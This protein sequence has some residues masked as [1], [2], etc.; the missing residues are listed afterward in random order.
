MLD[1]NPHRKNAGA[2]GISS[3]K[4]LVSW[5]L[6]RVAVILV[7]ASRTALGQL[8]PPP[9]PAPPGHEPPPDLR[10]LKAGFR[11]NLLA[12]AI[13]EMKAHREELLALEKKLALAQDFASAV[14]VRDERVRTEKQILTLEQEAAILVSRPAVGNAAKLVARIELK[15]SEA[16]LSDVQLDAKDGALTDWGQPNAGAT[17]QLSGLAPGGYEVLLRC[18]GPAGDVVVKEGFY[19]LTKTCKATNDKSVEQSLGTLRLRVGASSLTLGRA[20]SEKGTGWR[21][22]SVVLV[23]STI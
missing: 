17:W 2:L 9:A 14:R 13:P 10:G 12:A 23:P 1:C 20:Q 15:L 4:N 5:W 21:V 7:L 6:P 22:Y 19:S 16:K 18:T 11:K 3:H 8:L